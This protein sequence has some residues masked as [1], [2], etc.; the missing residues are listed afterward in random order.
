MPGGKITRAASFTIQ[1]PLNIEQQRGKDA[2]LLKLLNDSKSGSSEDE[3]TD[4]KEAHKT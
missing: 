2:M 4:V 3:A 1:K